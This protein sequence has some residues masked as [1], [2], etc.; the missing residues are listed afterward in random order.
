MPLYSR[1]R[2]DGVLHGLAERADG[3]L[4]GP[5]PAQR[6]P[7]VVI[8]ELA[9]AIE[10]YETLGQI[11]G[12]VVGLWADGLPMSEMDN[13]AAQ[14]Q[15]LPLGDVNTAAARYAIPEKSVLLLVGDRSKIEPGLKGLNLGTIVVLDNEG[16]VLEQIAPTLTYDAKI[17]EGSYPG[18][19]WPERYRK[20]KVPVLLLDGDKTFPFLPFGV[21][22]LSKVLANSSRRTLPGQDHGPAPEAIAPAIRDFL[23]A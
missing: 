21:E 22:A 5:R 4:R 15:M 3:P 8:V 18:Q 12:R 11:A 14:L 20:N 10:E 23:G 6:R 9:R 2:P 7:V 13:E 16:Q 1:D 17:V 19:K